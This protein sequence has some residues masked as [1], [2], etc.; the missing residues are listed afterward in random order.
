MIDGDTFVIE[1]VGIWPGIKVDERVRVLGVDTP[2]KTEA[3]FEEATAF[4]DAWLH[5]GPFEVIACKRD[6]FGRILGTVIRSG[7]SLSV[8]LIRN[9]HSKPPKQL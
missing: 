2:E 9:G 1:N 7:E 6:V 5:K 3:G 8:D 4:T